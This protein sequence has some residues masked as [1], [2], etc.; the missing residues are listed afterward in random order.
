MVFNY[1]LVN[2]ILETIFPILPDDFG[3]IYDEDEDGEYESNLMNYKELESAIFK[4]DDCAKINFGASKMV[5]TSY[6]LGN[7]AIKIP[8]NGAWWF[9][10]S[11][12]KSKPEEYFSSFCS[13]PGSDPSDYCL[14]EYEKYLDLKF[15]HLDCFVAKIL[16]YKTINNRRVFIQEFVTPFNNFVEEK[17]FNKPKTSA[18]SLKIVSTLYKENKINLN[19]DSEWLADCFDRYG[20]DKT[21]FFLTY[22]EEIDPDILEDAYEKNYGYREN[23]TPC[24]LDFSN[25]LD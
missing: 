24:L 19:I 4:I 6:H 1:K 12:E 7:I 3:T 23:G 15:K 21:K 22:C 16:P 17:Y 13:A 9:Y 5:I 2:K 14:A 25:F 20:E 10:R 8:F 11:D 18:K